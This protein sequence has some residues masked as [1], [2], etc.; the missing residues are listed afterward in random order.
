MHMQTQAGT[1]T[2]DG[3]TRKHVKTKIQKHTYTNK[4]EKNNTNSFKTRKHVGLLLRRCKRRRNNTNVQLKGGRGGGGRGEGDVLRECMLWVRK[5]A[6][7][8]RVFRAEGVTTG[9]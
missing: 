8:V 1:E 2:Q 6:Q 4:M 3:I 5:A 7:K 9:R